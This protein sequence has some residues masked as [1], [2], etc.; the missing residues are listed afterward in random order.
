VRA[1]DDTDPTIR[2]AAGEA[3]VRAGAAARP[4][5]RKLLRDADPAVRLRVGV[6]LTAAG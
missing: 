4:G 6:A 5:V 3:L 1:L 2:S